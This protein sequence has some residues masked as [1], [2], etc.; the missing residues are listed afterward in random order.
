VGHQALV[1]EQKHFD[2][3]HEA[4]QRHRKD[5][6]KGLVPMYSVLGRSQV[7]PGLLVQMEGKSGPET[8]APLAEM[9][10]FQKAGYSVSD[11]E[12]KDRSTQTDD[13]DEVIVDRS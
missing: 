7:T 8:A 13:R 3:G 10:C 11:L 12:T 5:R 4:K 6:R 2:L 9:K 1:L